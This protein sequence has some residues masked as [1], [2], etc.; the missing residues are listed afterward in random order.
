MYAATDDV[1]LISDVISDVIN[2]V[3]SDTMMA[4]INKAK[5]LKLRRIP[6]LLIML[7]DNHP[8]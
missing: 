8:P 6:I 3:I 5:L 1:S 7:I 2:D 4:M